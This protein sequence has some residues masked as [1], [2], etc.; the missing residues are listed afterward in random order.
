[1]RYDKD[2]K[3][4]A[5]SPSV[6]LVLF[7][8]FPI[9][10]DVKTR[11]IPAL[12]KDGAAQLHRILA[13]QTWGTIRTAA[14]QFGADAEV[15]YSGGSV[16][17]FQQWLGTDTIFIEQARGD[18]TDRLLAAA[19]PCPFIFFGADTPDL[20]VDIIG[21]AITALADHDSVVGP[22]EDGGYYLIGLARPMPE[23]FRDIAWSTADVLPATLARLKQS[24]RSHKI[25]PLLS[26]CDRPEDLIQWPELTA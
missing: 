4:S 14:Q 11:L 17:D 6:R 12:G 20:S 16:K 10:G 22:A 8:K 26:D 3:D 23:L 21:Q 1:L 15:Q 5:A 13:R 19:D 2:M 7:T 25:L 24:G 9:A 18:L